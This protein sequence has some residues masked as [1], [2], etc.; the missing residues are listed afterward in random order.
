MSLYTTAQETHRTQYRQAHLPKT[1]MCQ[2]TGVPPNPPRRTPAFSIGIKHR[3]QFRH[4]KISETDVDVDSHVPP[5]IS[6]TSFLQDRGSVP[7]LTRICRHSD[8][9]VRNLKLSPQALIISL[10][11]SISSHIPKRYQKPEMTDVSCHHPPPTYVTLGT[12]IITFELDVFIVMLVN[13]TTEVS[14]LKRDGFNS[15]V[16]P[17]TARNTSPSHLYHECHVRSLHRPAAVLPQPDFRVAKGIYHPSVSLTYY[18]PEN[19][20]IS[21]FLS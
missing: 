14:A 21:H 7:E 16:H 10:V 9:L 11:R 17:S 1:R 2:S 8:V 4:W 20:F 5:I 3:N 13:E 15:C 18:L 12:A 19:L 6:R